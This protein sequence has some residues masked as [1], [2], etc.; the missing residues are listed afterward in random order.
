MMLRK[1]V[2]MT[3]LACAVVC[4]VTQTPLGTADD[5]ET[6]AREYRVQL[7]KSFRRWRHEY[8]ARRDVGDTLLE[9]WRRGDIA[10]D[11]EAE[12]ANWFQTATANS[13]KT[14][15]RRLPPVPDVESVVSVNG[16]VNARR[17]AGSPVAPPATSTILIE[18]QEA[19]TAAAN[20]TSSTQP[21]YLGAIQRAL[22]S[23]ARD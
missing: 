20:T 19:D 14:S 10:A 2:L 8:D 4:L 21:S 7:Y 18:S 15:L 9:Q 22:L 1:I 16:V 23:A 12:V 11:R 3:L 6:A 5:V 17:D 13:R